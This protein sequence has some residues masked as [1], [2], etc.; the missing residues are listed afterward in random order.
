MRRCRSSPTSSSDLQANAPQ[1]KVTI[2]RDQASRFGISPQLIDDTLYD[3]FGQRQVAQYFTQLNTYHVILEVLP[4]LQGDLATLDQLYVKSPLTGAAGAA[5]HAGRGRHRQGRAALDRHQG[6]FPAVTLSFNLRP[7]VA[8]GEAV[9]AITKAATEIGMPPSV[10]GT[11]QGNAQ[12]FQSSLSSEPAADRR[13]PHRRLH[14]PRH[15]LRELHPSA[16]HPVDAAVGRRRRVA[17]AA[18]GPHATS[19]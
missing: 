6:Q 7:G 3:A 8:L 4:E 16:D 15:P 13:R 2:N 11:F 12:A 14:H 5:V 1:L 10:N 19:R 18:G 17:G 9:D